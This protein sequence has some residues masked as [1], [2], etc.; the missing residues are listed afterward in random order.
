LEA[1][2]C[3]CVCVRVRVHNID[4]IY[5]FAHLFLL[6]WYDNSPPHHL[7]Y[8]HSCDI[9]E[10]RQD[11]LLKTMT[12]IL[13]LLMVCCCLT[14]SKAHV[15]YVGGT[16]ATDSDACGREPSSPCRSLNVGLGLVTNSTTVVIEKGVYPLIDSANLSF[17]CVSNVTL[18][19]PSGREPKV[20]VACKEDTGLSFFNSS[21]ITVQNIEFVCC[22]VLHHSTTR[23]FSNSSFSFLDFRSAMYFLFCK[24]IYFDHVTVTH[25]NGTG[26]TLYSTNGDNIFQNCNF[27]HNIVE[28]GS[29]GGGGVYIEFIFCVP[30]EAE[31]CLNNSDFVKDDLLERNSN[32]NYT[33][34]NSYFGFNVAQNVREDTSYTFHQPTVLNHVAFGHGGG[35]NIY[36][37]NV[38]NSSVV[39]DNCE[40]DGNIAY[41]GAG[42]Y[43][44]FF[45]HCHGNSFEMYSSTVHDNKCQFGANSTKPAGT[46][47]AGGAIKLTYASAIESS[48][49]SLCFEN[50][51]FTNNSAYWGGGGVFKACPEHGRVNATNTIKFTDCSWSSNIG[52]LAAAIELTVLNFIDYGALTRPLFTR[53]SFRNNF[54]PHKGMKNTYMGTA[55]VLAD[56]LPVAFAES[57]I[58]DRNRR[59]ALV[60]ENTIV[61]FLPNCNATFISNTGRIGGGIGLSGYAYVRVHENT[62]MFFIDNLSWKY[63][64]AILSYSLAE[65][66]LVGL[67]NCFIQYSDVAIKNTTYFYF[68]NN[69]REGGDGGYSI[70]AI[71]LLPCLSTE[72][73][74]ENINTNNATKLVFCDD[75][76][77]FRGED[78]NCTTDIVTSPAVFNSTMYHME[79]IPGKSE[80]IPLETFDDKGNPAI[81]RTLLKGWSYSPNASLFNNSV[82]LTDH[83]LH[84]RGRPNST[85]KIGLRTEDPRA[86]YTE[87][88]V[89]LLPCPPG[90]K[91]QDP[92]ANL[93]TCVCSGTFG[94]L[95]Q[96]KPEEFQSNLRR[97]YWIGL[98]NRSGER[99]VEVV[100]LSVYTSRATQGEYPPLPDRLSR[101]DEALCGPTNRTGILCGACLP[102][103]SIVANSRDWH[104]IPCSENEAKYSWVFYLLLEF[105]PVTIFLV[106]ILLFHIN[107]T[108]GPAN[109]F[110]FFAQVLTAAFSIDG[111]GTIPLDRIAKSA[112]T[113]RKLYLFPYSIWNLKFF[114][115]IFPSYCLSPEL[116]LLEL[117]AVNYLAAAYPLFLII[118]FYV[119]ISLYDRGGIIYT[120]CNP[121]HTR[122][123][124][125]LRRWNLNQ[126]S[127][128][129]AFAT[130][131]ILSYTKF[132]LLSLYILEPGELFNS[133]GTHVAYVVFHNG[134]I[135]YLHGKHIP[136]VCIAVVVL[137]IFVIIPPFLLLYYPLQ[138]SYKRWKEG[139]SEGRSVFSLSASNHHDWTRGRLKQFL[140][141]FYGCYK[142]GLVETTDGGR[143]HVPTRDYRYFAGVYF[144]LRLVLFVTY[145]FTSIWVMHYILQQMICV[146]GILLFAIMRPYKNRWYNNLDA[147]IFGLLAIINVLTIYNTYMTAIDTDPATWAFTLQ[148]ILIFCP[149]IYLIVYILLYLWRMFQA[150]KDKGTTVADSK[151]SKYDRDFLDY[152]RDVDAERRDRRMNYYPPKPESDDEPDK[153]TRESDSLLKNASDSG[154]TEANHSSY[155]ST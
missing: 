148:Y 43:V 97:G 124:R 88:K 29:P 50:C 54:D 117:I 93:T 24:N 125:C 46:E 128:I 111:D 140:E 36:F 31:Q 115:D 11:K 123:I 13:T 121:I 78:K 48:N 87:V 126:R 16:N 94:G 19:G 75:N 44:E 154:L 83:T 32:A 80:V 17:V 18:R 68:E 101:L 14:V 25:S 67:G 60:V 10:M 12:A 33:F 116:D 107:I 139:R 109:G 45:E 70:S 135:D 51:S 72:H 147:S 119:F 105:V 113:L 79:V 74:P 52:K 131:L 143:I 20:R 133:E 63:G 8:T 81:D 122:L 114:E 37:W 57:V 27:S 141:T 73:T 40:I 130:F 134:N 55:T 39:M 62:S 96:C 127:V 59:T 61:D 142:D 9:A 34:N 22:G 104:C 6:S 56:Y 4:C 71:S 92:D 118:L 2:G 58:F 76:W 3:V 1:D 21:D 91:A 99:P 86:V 41:W 26:L 65:H 106:I 102:N 77:V 144:L 137:I 108:T 5:Y 151:V 103:H 152:Y 53:C 38:H 149:L 150:K 136:L 120:I 100:G 84:L 110:V 69:L 82:Y 145:A 66:G 64:S 7:S 89:T 112:D 153:S 23:S 85:V 132:T 98:Y 95:L 155:G 28:P 90:F 47:G 129:D 138:E 42:V 49:N 30:G 146:I 15:V 35:L